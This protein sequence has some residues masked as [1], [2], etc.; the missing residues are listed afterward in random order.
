[1]I[2][3][4]S[5]NPASTAT[6]GAGTLNFPT[7]PTFNTGTNTPA[8]FATDLLVNSVVANTIGFGWQPAANGTNPLN[9]NSTLVPGTSNFGVVS[10]GGAS[11]FTNGVNLNNGTLALIATSGTLTTGFI[12]SGPFGT[13]SLNLA[14]GV[15]LYG[16]VAATVNNVVNVN[17]NITF[18]GTVAAN[19]VTLASMINL[20]GSA[21]TLTVTYPTVTATLSGG[22]TGT[23]GLTK[24]G[25]GILALGGGVNYSGDTT[26]NGGK[27]VA[28]AA[29]ITSSRFVVGANALFDLN[30]GAVTL[31]SL[32]GNGL[33]TSS[34]AARVL[35]IGNDNTN[36]TFDGVLTSVTT[37]NS[38]ALTK[39][40]T[41]TQTLTNKESYTGA[42]VINAGGLTLSGAASLYN[43]TAALAPTITIN[44][45]GTL[46]LDNSGT[47]TAN[48]IG[49]ILLPPVNNTLNPTVGSTFAPT[50]IVALV[51]GTL[52]I[53]GSATGSLTESIL[54]L[55]IGVGPN[56]INITPGAGGTN[57]LVLANYTSPVATTAGTLFMSGTGLGT[58]AP[59]AN[60]ASVTINPG[61]VPALSGTGVGILGSYATGTD[62][63][64]TGFLTYGPNGF[65][66]VGFSELPALPIMPTFPGQTG[67]ANVLNTAVATTNN[68]GVGSTVNM[69]TTTTV[70]SLTLNNGSLV[71]LG[72]NQVN[73]AGAAIPAA[74]NLY[75][76]AARPEHAHRLQQR[77]R[78]ARHEQHRQR[79]RH[80]RHRGQPAHHPRRSRRQPDAECLHRGRSD[81]RRGQGGRRH[82]PHSESGER[83][84]CFRHQPG[85]RHPRQRRG[86]HSFW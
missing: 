29:F 64:N 36:Q 74:G 72:G 22:I 77:H 31:G 58:A 47:N 67:L 80:R 42:T 27:V 5:D 82:A 45:G 83:L 44:T 7:A 20:G 66:V 78:G 30:A 85:H 8:R 9:L 21:R 25:D 54:T 55:S 61:A 40:G 12:S 28:S 57:N 2:N 43:V 49:G 24:A 48:R 81:R 37:A 33:V 17:G 15:T 41:G 39:I 10:L 69:T 70:N 63:T 73:V 71:S 86:E 52:N 18:G 50:T 46:T 4:Q 23:G 65:R 11:T 60:L 79:R 14:N 19:N 34:A 68:V 26:I 13:G 62:G 3:A 1:M 53:I 84:R 59:A 75:N 35:T 16:G 56:A 38:L 6:L 76:S 51:G 32:S